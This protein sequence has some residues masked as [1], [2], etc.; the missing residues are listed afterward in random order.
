MSA[1][2]AGRD[3][4]LKLYELAIDEHHYYIDTRDSRVAFYV[5]VLSALGCSKL[6][7]GTTLRFCLCHLC[8]YLLCRE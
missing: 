5:G 3:D 8:S 1:T 6:R 4:L 2:P 7:S